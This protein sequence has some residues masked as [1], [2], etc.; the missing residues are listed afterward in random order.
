MG[1]KGP[2]GEVSSKSDKGSILKLSR[3]LNVLRPNISLT[4]LWRTW[5]SGGR[6]GL[7]TLTDLK[8]VIAPTMNRERKF[9]VGL[10]N[11]DYLARLSLLSYI[12]FG[13][14][15]SEGRGK[16]PDANKVVKIGAFVTFVG[17][18]SESSEMTNLGG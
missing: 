3:H 14:G 1:H 5:E 7:T 9:R 12:L 10:L 4:T 18:S 6:D 8:D 13:G 11:L 2:S 16:V 17:Q 15:M